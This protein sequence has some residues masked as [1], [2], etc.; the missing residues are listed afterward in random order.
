M[1][2]ETYART[3]YNN[4][5]AIW[6]AVDSPKFHTA[7]SKAT[8]RQQQR[9]WAAVVSGNVRRL[10]RLIRV[11]DTGYGTALRQQARNLGVLYYSKLDS[12][13]LKELLHDRPKV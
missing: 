5:R 8:T 13:T 7:W 3:Q 9:L 10:H 1:T 2:P 4:A 11:L 6:R 12:K